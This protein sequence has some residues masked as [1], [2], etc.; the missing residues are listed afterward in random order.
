VSRH[1]GQD[2]SPVEISSKKDRNPWDYQ[3]LLGVS[4]VGIEPTTRRL[5][6]RPEQD[7]IPSDFRES[8]SSI[9]PGCTRGC[10]DTSELARLVERWPTLPDH[11]RAAVM[12]L[13]NTAPSSDAPPKPNS[14][15][16]SL[17]PGFEKRSG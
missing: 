1:P 6:D 15:D 13:V 4:R 7:E 14:L 11:I 16:E 9:D 2:T 17:P 12:A 5:K 3:G 8:N 10:T